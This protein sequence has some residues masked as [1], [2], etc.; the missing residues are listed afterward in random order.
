MMYKEVDINS[1]LGEGF[2]EKFARY[3]ISCIEDEKKNPQYDKAYGEWA[4]SKGFLEGSAYAYGLNDGKC[5]KFL[6]DY[7]YYKIWP[8]FGWMIK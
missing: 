6:S 2:S 5:E 7:D 1:L 8:V 3:Y 4:L